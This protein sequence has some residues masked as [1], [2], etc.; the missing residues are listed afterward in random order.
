[1]S[2]YREIIV[3]DPDLNGF[4]W[5]IVLDEG[6]LYAEYI[7][8]RNISTMHT[9]FHVYGESE[10]KRLHRMS[11]TKLSNMVIKKYFKRLR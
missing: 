10:I 5:S 7:N 1:M 8:Y 4:D 3:E 9:F 2:R 11:T 6:H